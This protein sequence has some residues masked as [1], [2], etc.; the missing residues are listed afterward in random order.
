MGSKELDRTKQLTLSLH[1]KKAM[2][3]VYCKKFPLFAFLTVFPSQLWRWNK[4][5]PPPAPPFPSLLP[6]CWAKPGDWNYKWHIHAACW[7]RRL[8]PPPNAS[9]TS[10]TQSSPCPQQGSE[11]SIQVGLIRVPLTQLPRQQPSVWREQG[12]EL[13]PSSPTLQP[14]Q[15]PR[16][17]RSDTSCVVPSHLVSHNLLSSVLLLI[18]QNLNSHTK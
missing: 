2:K 10:S 4:F 11:P 13:P 17:G 18:L 5:F 9:G 7:Q 1:L 16:T 15:P 14:N 3:A 8:W 6:E 12:W